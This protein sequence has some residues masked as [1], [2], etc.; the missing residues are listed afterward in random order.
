[1]EHQEQTIHES[2]RGGSSGERSSRVLSFFQSKPTQPV[3]SVSPR[4]VVLCTLL[5]LS[6]KECLVSL[7]PS[8]GV[9]QLPLSFQS[10]LS[11]RVGRPFFT[12]TLSS[13]SNSFSGH[14]VP[15]RTPGRTMGSFK[16]PPRDEPPKSRPSPSKVPQYETDHR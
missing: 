15:E 8:C 10:V 12:H 7:L 13:R 4:W 3:H 6:H 5:S 16:G 2:N 9:P 1:M 11:T 14:L